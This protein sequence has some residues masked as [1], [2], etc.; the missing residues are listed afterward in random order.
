MDHGEQV[1]GVFD[2]QGSVQSEWPAG[3]HGGSVP[4]TVATVEEKAIF[5]RTPLAHLIKLQKGPIVSFSKLNEALNH[6]QQFCKISCGLSTP[7]R[8]PTKIGVPK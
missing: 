6:I 8:T 5:Q 2:H 4:A 3:R 1:E 7:S